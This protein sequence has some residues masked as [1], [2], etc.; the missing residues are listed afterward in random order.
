[1][2]SQPKEETREGREDQEGCE[3]KPMYQMDATFQQE[4]VLV[5]LGYPI[6]KSTGLTQTHQ[7]KVT[8]PD[9]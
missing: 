3:A 8:N 6:G 7:G 2:L 9:S 4:P 5:L 1:V